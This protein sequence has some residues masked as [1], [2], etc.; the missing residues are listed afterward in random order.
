MS[1]DI[2]K[3]IFISTAI[4]EIHLVRFII[5]KWDINLSKK[6][7]SV[8]LNLELKLRSIKIKHL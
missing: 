2:K 1:Y 5:I 4:G 3:G 8:N 6:L 7:M